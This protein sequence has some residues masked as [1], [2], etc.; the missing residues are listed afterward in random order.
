MNIIQFQNTDPLDVARIRDDT[1]A[2]MSLNRFIWQPCTQVES[3][4]KDCFKYVYREA[5]IRGFGAAYRLDD[6]H[7]RLNLIVGPHHMNQG[8][9][10]RLLNKIEAT[11]KKINGKFLQARVLENMKSSLKFARA[12]G[13]TEIHRMRGMSLSKPDFSFERWLEL[14][15]RLSAKGVVATTLKEE[16]EANKNPIKKLARLHR[17]SQTGW[18]SPDPTWKDNSPIENLESR[19]TAITLP[20]RFTIISLKEEYV[21]YTSAKNKTTATA[22][23]PNYRGIGIATY[24]KA[25]D[26]KRCISEGDEYFES[27]T[28]NPA[29]QKVNEK[30]GYKLNGLCEVRFLKE[31]S[32]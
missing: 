5:A 27:A 18:P 14:G 11:T 26:L 4:E 8:I 32:S 20:D 1:F 19:F 22:V 2:G 31:L 28:A 13:F 24:M 25:L 30:L 6:T 21:G 9:G 29:M 17:D 16:L 12:R 7:F 10:T 15:R 3:L 23:H